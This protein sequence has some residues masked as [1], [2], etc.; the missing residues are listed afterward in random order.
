MKKG[1]V[2]FFLTLL[3]LTLAACGNGER[4]VETTPTPAPTPSETVPVTA[5]AAEPTAEPTPE[6][7]PEEGKTLVVYFS[8]TSNTGRV[9]QA[10]AETL[11]AD[12]FEIIPTNPYS[13]EDL[14][15]RDT[16]SRVNAE[17][18]DPALQSVELETVTPED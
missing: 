15:W 1:S 11:E 16:S 14:N 10:I 8:A 2:F 4:T 7:A 17:H 5:P 9:A 6:P 13:T 18:D 3:L 12:I